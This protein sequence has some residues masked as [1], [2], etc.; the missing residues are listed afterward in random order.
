MPVHPVGVQARIGADGDPYAVRDFTA[1]DPALGDAAGLRALVDDL[2]RRGMRVIYD[3]TL[4][5]ASVDNVLTA[6]HP[7]WFTHDAARQAVLP[8]AEPR[9]FQRF[10]FSSKPLRA[11]LL[12]AMQDWITA[13]GFDGLRFDDADITPLDFLDEIR[14]ALVPVRA[15]IA[16]IA[17]STDELH[18]LDACDLTYDGGA[19]DHAAHRP[20]RSDGRRGALAVGRIDLYLPARR[21]AHA[22]ARRKEQGRAFRY[23]GHELHLAAAAVVFTLDGVPHVLMGQEFNEP[24]W[25]N[26]TSLFDGFA[27]DWN[28]FDRP[29]FD[30]YRN[31]IAAARRLSPCARARSISCAAARPAC[32][33]TGAA[34]PSSASWWR[35]TCRMRRALPHGVRRAPAAV[36]ARR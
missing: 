7:E 21:A 32:S 24:R 11:W 30:H 13:Y 27:L 20:G 8:G 23:F 33:C 16:L 26:W 34:R 28:S 36:C 3:W 2:H 5:R 18:H 4:N 29:T 15:D 10:D 35:S 25:E 12:A 9:L 17:Q 31:L 14:A 1:I 19:R 6:S 22:L